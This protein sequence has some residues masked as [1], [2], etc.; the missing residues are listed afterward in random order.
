MSTPLLLTTDAPFRALIDRAQS[1]PEIALDCEFH[2]EKRYRPTLYLVQIEALGEAVAVDATRVDL[3]PLAALLESPAVNKLFHAGR[4]D[5]RLLAKATG[6]SEVRAIL[7]TQVAAAFLGHGLTIG[8]AR[9][10]KA[11][12]D[13]EL[14]KGSQFTDWS[15]E[16]TAE[17]VDYALN[18]VRYLPKL[19]RVLVAQL[20]E[21]GRLEWALEASRAM[22]ASALTEPD[23]SKLYRKI[24]GF[25]SLN[26]AQ[27]G[28]LRELAIWRDRIAAAENCRPEGVASDPGLKQLALRPPSK[29]G[30]LR[31]MR[32]LGLGASDRFWPGLRDAI[33]R[34]AAEPEPPVVFS[35]VDPRVESMV[36]LLGAVRRVVAVEHD[37]AP[38]LLASTAD[39][40][41]LAE[42]QLG[43]RDGSPGVE[44]LGGWREPLIGRPL[45][46]TLSGDISV[47]VSPASAS[48]LALM[49]A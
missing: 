12:L 4:E 42:W 2:G 10:V 31:G 28:A 7:D 29:S 21:R 18:D 49:R 48:G 33:A 35:D 40:R 24:S 15:R 19:A 36:A 26:P 37:L 47:R 27:L 8:Y 22:G 6:A 1:A 23:P 14:D 11:L 17:Q 5:V 30:Q 41:S 46:D 44:A 39:L 25:A 20:E 32:G 45:L 43:G 13:V 9:L 16:L 38:E 3:R 34:G